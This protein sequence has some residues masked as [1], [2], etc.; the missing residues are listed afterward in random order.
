MWCLQSYTYHLCQEFKFFILQDKRYVEQWVRVAANGGSAAI[1]FCGLL[2][3]H[4]KLDK[5]HAQLSIVK[6]FPLVSEADF[7][8]LWKSAKRHKHFISSLNST[9]RPC[10]VDAPAVAPLYAHKVNIPRIFIAPSYSYRGRSKL[11]YSYRSMLARANKIAAAHI[12]EHRQKQQ[13]LLDATTA[14]AR[15]VLVTG[16]V[17]IH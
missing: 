16:F 3:P 14:L 5:V 7:E 17:Y 12:V 9:S 10:L 2:V 13:R 1:A 11:G 6:S 8:T 15:C 4:F